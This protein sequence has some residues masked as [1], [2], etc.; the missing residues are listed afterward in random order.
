M[1]PGVWYHVIWNTLGSW[2]PGDPRGFRNRDHRIHSTGDYRNPPPRSEHANLLEYNRARSREKVTVPTAVRPAIVKSVLDS[3]RRADASAAAL[4]VAALSTFICCR[5][6]Q[7]ITTWL[8]CWW[9]RSK[10]THH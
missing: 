10:P 7:W 2:L 8:H 9:A 3:L 4:S 1:P 5:T 6:C